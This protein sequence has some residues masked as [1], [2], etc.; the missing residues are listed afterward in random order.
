MFPMTQHLECVV[1][2]TRHESAGDTA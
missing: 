1:R 2:L